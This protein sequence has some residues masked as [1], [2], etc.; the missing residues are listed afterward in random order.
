[1]KTTSKKIAL[2]GLLTVMVFSFSG[3][4]GIDLSGGFTSSTGNSRTDVKGVL[5]TTDGGKTWQQKNTI[6]GSENT[7]STLDIGALAIDPDNTSTLY[8]G[9]LG[10]SI[11]KTTDG[12]DTWNQANDESGKL[13]SDAFIYDIEVEPGNSNLVY[14]A[15]LN[16][17]RGVLL[18]TEDGGKNW[19]EVYIST[20]AGKQVNRVQIDP[21]SK[22][23]IYIG[24]EQGGF[25][26]SMNRGND[27]QEVK[28]FELSTNSGAAGQAQNGVKDFVI[29]YKNPKGIIVLTHSGLFKT[30]DGG[31]NKEK[32]WTRL[33]E[34]VTDSVGV[35]MNKINFI[36]SL[37]IDPQNPLMIYM[38]YLNLVF[39]TRDGG[40]NWET[41][42]TI[43]TPATSSK[44]TPNIE[45]IGTVNG[46][47]FYGSGNAIYKS[48][49]K[50]RTWSSF[51]IPIDGDV[52]YTVS[53]PKDPNI[54]YVGSFIANTKK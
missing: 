50:G 16:D 34:A 42:P 4:M 3:C 29:D 10:N 51:D 38:P 48:D 8:L 21:N 47:I 43:T 28:W 33:T 25:L 9:T 7:L 17:N 13:K 12:G 40:L 32:S 49:N 53:D 37:T 18:R 27:W 20:E 30:V 44:K 35:D 39:L 52:K 14:A 1:M 45:K 22:N 2:T 6:A 31:A 41:L 46:S 19:A 24:T 11:L 23:V 15:A 26:K 54:I 36:Y 5:K